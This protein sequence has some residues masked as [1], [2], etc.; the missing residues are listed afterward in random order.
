[1]TAGSLTPPPAHT[2]V[3][4]AFVFMSYPPPFSA[5]TYPPL[6]A[7]VVPVHFSHALWRLCSPHVRTGGHIPRA[8]GLV[9]CRRSGVGV[10]N[11]DNEARQFARKGLSLGR[12][13]LRAVDAQP[14]GHRSAPFGGARRQGWS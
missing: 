8:V 1:M 3:A 14:R 7:S 11:V 2:S 12:G 5:R 4:I 6:F 10:E 9:R 13:A